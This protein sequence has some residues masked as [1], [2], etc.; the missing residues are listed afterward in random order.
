MVV[1]RILKRVTLSHRN[2][3]RSLWLALL[4]LDPCHHGRPLEQGLA[5]P[6]LGGFIATLRPEIM[7]AFAEYACGHPINDGFAVTLQARGD[8]VNREILPFLRNLAQ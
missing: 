1:K 6:S 3:A 8:F 7:H 4:S 5:M 2:D